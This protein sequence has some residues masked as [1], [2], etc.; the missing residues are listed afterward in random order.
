MH[1]PKHAKLPVVPPRI[2]DVARLDLAESF[3]SDL[4][5][6]R[7]GAE[8]TSSLSS[9]CNALRLTRPVV[10]SIF[11]DLRHQKLIE[12]KGLT[13]PDPRHAIGE[14]YSFSLTVA[15]GRLASERAGATQYIGPTPVSLPAYTATVRAQRAKLKLSRELLRD[16]LS[17]LVLP[18]SVI[19]QI[20]PALYSQRSLFL[21]GPTGNGKTS[22]AERLVRAYQDLVL[23]PYAVEVDG[24]VIAVYDPAVHKKANVELEEMDA[25][26]VIC[27]RPCVMAGGELTARMLD[28]DLDEGSNIYA[29]PLQMKANNGILVI[30]DFGRQTMSPQQLLNRWIVPF[31]RHVDYLALR[32]GVKFEIPFEIMVVFATNLDPNSLADEAFLRRIPNKIHIKSPDA[33]AFDTIFERLL[34]QRKIVGAAGA[35]EYLRN[36]CLRLNRGKL[37]ACHPRDICDILDWISGFEGQPAQAD[38]ETLETAADL[39]FAHLETPELDS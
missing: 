20:G 21:Y 36:L 35:A 9:L 19:G 4:I 23:I 13:S 31:D 15:G 14:D 24:Q 25:R 2:F 16:I 29:A 1:S 28:L 33:Q 10:E 39:Y 11:H 6:R 37:R 34:E 22:V 7:I 3:V 5:V 38:P 26:W 18:E 8:G 27:Q 12:V 30:D 17:E 32:Y